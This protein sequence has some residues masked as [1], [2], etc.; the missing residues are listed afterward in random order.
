MVSNDEIRQRL[1]NKRDGKSGYGYL[2]C[3]KCGGYYELQPGEKPEDFNLNCDCGGHLKYIENLKIAEENEL[4]KK[5][6]TTLILMGYI[7]V[8]FGVIPIA[9]SAIS[10]GIGII[11]YRR[12]GPDRI[13]GIIITLIS[14]IILIIVSLLIIFMYS[15][16]FKIYPV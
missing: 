2:V 6:S 11:L 8:F 16:I 10:L 9:G 1:D 7:F 15:M 4:S 12:G 13:H 3:D 5:P 14:V